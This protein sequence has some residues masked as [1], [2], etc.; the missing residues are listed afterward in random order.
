METR[1]TAELK[2]LMGL[3]YEICN[4]ILV[5]KPFYRFNAINLQNTFLCIN[6]ERNV[7]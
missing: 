7:L 5:M 1:F 6:K 2:F 4:I 3:H